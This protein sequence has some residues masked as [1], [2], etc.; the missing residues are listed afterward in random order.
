MYVF[1]RV[2]VFFS[3]VWPGLGGLGRSGLLSGS[4]GPLVPWSPGPLVP[5]SLVPWSPLLVFCIKLL[6]NYNVR[7]LVLLV[8]C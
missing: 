5:R 3:V 8:L 1:V 2:P 6:K 4:P 7:G